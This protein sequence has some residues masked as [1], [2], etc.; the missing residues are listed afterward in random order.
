MLWKESK[1][2]KRYGFQEGSRRLLGRFFWV[3]RREHISQLFRIS[4]VWISYL[5]LTSTYTNWIVFLLSLTLEMRRLRLNHFLY[6]VSAWAIHHT[7]PLTALSKS[8]VFTVQTTLWP[9]LLSAEPDR[10]PLYW[11]LWIWNYAGDSLCL[12]T[13]NTK[14]RST[15]QI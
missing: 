13:Q 9:G 6:V 11:S 1:D 4:E 10:E 15:W 3:F 12:C 2:S 7:D 5:I 14:H 8:T